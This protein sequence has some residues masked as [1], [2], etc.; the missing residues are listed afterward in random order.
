MKSQR[1][2]D[3]NYC[4]IPIPADQPRQG[5]GKLLVLGIDPLVVMRDI[6]SVSR[7]Q[8]LDAL[9]WSARM[10]DEA[11]VRWSQLGQGGLTWPLERTYR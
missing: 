2:N 4:L 9:E 3:L 10:L 8:A 7:E 1:N 5:K 11:A 6:A